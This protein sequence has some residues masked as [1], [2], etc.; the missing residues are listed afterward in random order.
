MKFGAIVFCT[1]MKHV[2]KFALIAIVALGVSA[3]L[4]FYLNGYLT[5]SKASETEA[6]ISFSETKKTAKGGDLIQVGLT[7]TT[8]KGMSAVDISFET[9][10]ENLNFLY[11]QSTSQLPVG[12]D[13]RVLTENMSTT[14]TVQGTKTVRRMMFVSKKPETQLPKS[15]VIPLHFAVVNNG[16]AAAKST[17]TVNLS[18]SQ[19]SGPSVPSNLFT[20][21]TDRTPLDFTV[22]IEDPRA[23]LVTNLTCDSMC[24]SAS[25]LKWT[26]SANEDGYKIYKD[27]NLLTSLGKNTTAYPYNWCGDFNSHKYSVISHNAKGSVSTTDPTISCAC[28][29][30]PTAAPPTPTPIMPTNSS[31]IIFRVLFPDVDSTVALLSNIKVTVFKDSGEAVCLD[32]A[33]CA[34]TVTFT[35]MGSS[36]YFASPQMQFNLK[37]NIPYS[38]VI[39]QNHTIQ[40]TYKHVFL[41]WKQVL[42]CLGNINESACGQLISEVGKRPLY[43]GD[44]QGIDTTAEGYNIIDIKDLTAVG[45]I[46]DS[47]TTLNRKMPEGD[48]NFDGGTDVKDYGIVARNLGKKGD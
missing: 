11:P 6:S 19:I 20:L 31:D 29:R 15:I 36:S 28:Q 2:L 8:E 40:R 45:V 30:C 24:A 10:G 37:D 13:D 18:T 22:E 1:N 17:L 26:D 21:K 9:T 16:V 14:Q 46:S 35:R 41:K 34:Q 25:I 42:G 38:I 32:G 5:K 12:F 27:G 39:K 43:S 23:A 7:V 47:Q 4:W 3:G 33:D 48:M 44:M